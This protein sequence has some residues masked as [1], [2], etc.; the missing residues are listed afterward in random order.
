MKSIICLI[1]LIFQKNVMNYWTYIFLEDQ[2]YLS[3]KSY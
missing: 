1:A 3:L 2:I